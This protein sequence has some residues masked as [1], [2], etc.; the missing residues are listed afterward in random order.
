MVNSFTFGGN[1]DAQAYGMN[2]DGNQPI[3]RAE[4]VQKIGLQGVNQAGINSPG[5]SP[6]FNI[7][8]YDSI[9]IRLGGYQH[10]AK[11]SNVA[12]SVTWAKGRHVV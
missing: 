1:Y 2:L 12:E 5:G 8:G 3:P 11:N 10:A 9:Y 7:S 6:V 4:I